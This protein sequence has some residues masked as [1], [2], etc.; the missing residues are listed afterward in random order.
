MGVLEQ[1]GGWCFQTKHVRGVEN[2]S[3]DGITRWEK[4]KYN[5]G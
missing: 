3:A 5:R 1:I 2:G 4:A